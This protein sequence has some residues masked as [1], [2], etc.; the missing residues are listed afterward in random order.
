MTHDEV[1]LI[2]TSI[3]HLQ[4][5]Y[6]VDTV[7]DLLFSSKYIP[8]NFYSQCLQ[9]SSP[10]ILKPFPH[11]HIHARMLQKIA[12]LDGWNQITFMSHVHYNQGKIVTIKVK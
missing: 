10:T 6:D 1:S 4:S 5:E 12:L 9:N 3:L 11:T 2:C 7:I 8:V